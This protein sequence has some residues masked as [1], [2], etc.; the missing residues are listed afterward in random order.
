VV[1]FFAWIVVM[2]VLMF[3]AIGL[4]DQ[5]AVGAHAPAQYH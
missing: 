5:V 4:Q 2:A 1:T 3:M